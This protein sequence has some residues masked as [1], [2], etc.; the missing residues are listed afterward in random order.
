MG[1]DDGAKPGDVVGAIANE[2][3]ID[4]DH[5][6]HIKLHDSYSTVDLPKGMPKDMLNTLKKVRICNKTIFI[7]EEAKADH[8]NKPT[9]D[10]KKKRKPN[11]SAK[12]ENSSKT[13]KAKNKKADSKSKVKKRKAK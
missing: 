12:P 3:G 10:K 9:P 6:G 7:S 5:I 11:T 4:G 13:D 8:S 2:S 1:R